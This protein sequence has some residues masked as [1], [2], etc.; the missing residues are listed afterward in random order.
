MNRIFRSLKERTASPQ[1]LI[2]I[3]LLLMV[4]GVVLPFLMVMHIL[5]STFFLNFFSYGASVSGLFLGIIGASQV[6][7]GGKR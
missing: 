6:I 1:G 3:G 2:V 4:M 7:G 5:E